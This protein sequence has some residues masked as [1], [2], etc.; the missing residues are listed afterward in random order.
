MQS[1]YRPLTTPLKEGGVNGGM[2]SYR[3]SR[4]QSTGQRIT[5]F[6]TVHI[7]SPTR[8]QTA[9]FKSNM[10]RRAIFKVSQQWNIVSFPLTRQLARTC[11]TAVQ[12]F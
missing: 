5:L 2:V 9:V 10:N 1:H 6:Y 4:G 12:T 7:I 3:I 8:R 11:G